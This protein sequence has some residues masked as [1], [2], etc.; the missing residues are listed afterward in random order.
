MSD[1]KQRSNRT[2]IDGAA[3]VRLFFGRLLCVLGLALVLPG[4]YF[5]SVAG[6]SCLPRWRTRLCL[7]PTATA[8]R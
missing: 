3:E 1:G 7:R 6:G 2:R 4:A 5:V 8:A